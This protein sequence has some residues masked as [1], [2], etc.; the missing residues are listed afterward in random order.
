MENINSMTDAGAGG[1][2]IPSTS[3][4]RHFEEDDDS[5]PDIDEN[6]PSQIIDDDD[7]DYEP[8]P[9]KKI[10]KKTT[11][12]NKK[13]APVAIPVTAVTPKTKA[14]KQKKTPASAKKPVDPFA[15]N[16]RCEGKTLEEHRRSFAQCIQTKMTVEKFHVAPKC[17]L[18]LDCSL[19]LFRALIAPDATNLVPEEF[20]EN[21]PAVLATVN[22]THKIGNLFGH[23]KIKKGTRYSGDWHAQKCDIIFIPDCH[24]LRVW[25]TMA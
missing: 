13:A 8:S 14:P 15:E 12:G 25:W 24:E 16:G 21:T 7:S 20:D 23:T 9:M 5:L 6:V 4:K 2:A 18:I 1:D 17:H 11:P 10:K 22:G 3:G 19:A